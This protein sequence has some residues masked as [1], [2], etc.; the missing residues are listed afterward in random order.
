MMAEVI[1]KRR[2]D[3]ATFELVQT[4]ALLDAARPAPQS[5]AQQEFI[6]TVARPALQRYQADD[7]VGAVA[8]WMQRTCWP[9]YRHT[10]ERVLPGAAVADAG[11]FFGQ[12]LP[13]VQQWPF[14]ADDACRVPQPVL[15]VLGEKSRP[16]FRERRDLLLAWLPHVESFVLPGAT[17]L[18]QVANPRGMAVALAAFFARH[19]A[20][21]SA[22]HRCPSAPIS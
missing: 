8:I 21:V 4:L 22:W 11:A 18:L 2:W 12:E 14:T 7:K 16:T 19:A 13:A 1:S 17:H 20:A 10:L 5:E 6:A 15:A 3:R 9:D